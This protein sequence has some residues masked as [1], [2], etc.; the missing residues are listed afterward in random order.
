VRMDVHTAM[1][2]RFVHAAPTINFNEVKYL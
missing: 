1:R 2:E